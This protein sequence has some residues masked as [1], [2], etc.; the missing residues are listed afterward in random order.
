MKKLSSI[1]MSA[2]FIAVTLISM[3]SCSENDAPEMPYITP[4]ENKTNTDDVPPYE[5]TEGDSG[6]GGESVIFPDHS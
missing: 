1:L 5:V 6:N 4:S 2:L 3:T